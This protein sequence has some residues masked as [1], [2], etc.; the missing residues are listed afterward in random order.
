LGDLGAVDERR[1]RLLTGVLQAR[2]ATEA[3]ASQERTGKQLAD[4]SKALV[5]ATDRLA[6]FT[7]RLMAATVVLVVVTILRG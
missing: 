2:I 3:S 4:A 7:L 6:L 1:V 5:T